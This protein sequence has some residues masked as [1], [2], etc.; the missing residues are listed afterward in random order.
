MIARRSLLAGAALIAASFVP[1]LAQQ[2]GMAML[3]VVHLSPDAPA[4]DVLAGTAVLFNNLPYEG[5]TDY[6][7]VPAGSY[8]VNINVAG[9]TTRAFSKSF[10]IPAGVAIT[11]FAVGNITQGPNNRPFDLVAAVD[12]RAQAGVGRFKVRVLHAAPA[13]GTVDGYLVSP[14]TPLT[15]VSPAAGAS[16]GGITPY[17]T[18]PNGLYQLRLTPTGTKTVAAQTGSQRLFSENWTLIA[19]NP[20]TMGGPVRFLVLRDNP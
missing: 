9:T 7:S 2:P 3:R 5:F 4:V 10:D 17:L 11:V 19:L 8:I 12:D 6:I 20:A 16:F 1:A 18:V 14:Y 15:T 13:V